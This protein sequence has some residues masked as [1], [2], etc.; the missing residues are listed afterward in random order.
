MK[1]IFDLDLQIRPSVSNNNGGSGFNSDSC[2][3]PTGCTGCCTMGFATCN[4]FS[5]DCEV[6]QFSVCGCDTT[7]IC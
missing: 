1:D 7:D 2:S 4:C 6:T 3:C 5:D